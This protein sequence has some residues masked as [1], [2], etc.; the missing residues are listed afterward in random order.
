MSQRITLKVLPILLAACIL[1]IPAF[2]GLTRLPEPADGKTFGTGFYQGTRLDYA[3]YDTTLPADALKFDNAPG[4]GRYVYAY[5]LFNSSN[6]SAIGFLSLHG[7]EEGAIAAASDVG[8]IEDDNGVA[9]TDRFLNAKKT[10]ATYAFGNTGLSIGK[11]T[12]FLTIRSDG[13]PKIGSFTFAPPSDSDIVV[14][15]AD[16]TVPEPATMSLLL[17]GAVSMLR[18]RKQ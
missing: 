4:Q 14:P 11:N 9:P 3:V 8:S 15:D 6:S 5:Q 1:S 12:W 16:T 13:K 2:A 10:V 18:K 7:I 17:L